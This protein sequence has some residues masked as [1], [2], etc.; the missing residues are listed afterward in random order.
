MNADEQNTISG[1]RTNKIKTSTK[2]MIEFKAKPMRMYCDV[3]RLRIALGR[4]FTYE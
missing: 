1:K 3:D 2:L 4:P